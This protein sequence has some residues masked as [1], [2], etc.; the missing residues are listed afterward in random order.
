MV[1]HMPLQ[2]EP[3]GKSV[4]QLNNFV[5][6]LVL[7]ELHSWVELAVDHGQFYFGEAY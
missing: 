2:W 1:V 4:Y 5:H 6:A 3:T 7:N